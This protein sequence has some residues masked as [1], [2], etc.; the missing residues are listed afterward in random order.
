M[1]SRKNASDS[2]FVDGHRQKARTTEVYKNGD[3]TVGDDSRPVLNTSEMA[4]VGKDVT[5]LKAL[6]ATRER[7]KATAAAALAATAATRVH[8]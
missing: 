5:R 1:S 6:L 8:V 7:D 2:M 3:P 4:Q